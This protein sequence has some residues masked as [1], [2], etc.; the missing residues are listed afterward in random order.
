[1]LGLH[2]KWRSTFMEAWPDEVIALGLPQE[3]VILSEQDRMAIGSRTAAFRDIFE[4]DEIAQISKDLFAA[5]DEKLAVFPEGGHARLGGCSFKKPGFFQKGPAYTGQ[6]LAPYIL[7][8]N[9]RVASLLASSLED[10]FDVGLFIRPWRDMPR[11][12]EFRLFMR[13]R[14]FV[15]ASQYFHTDVY[16]QIEPNAQHIAAALIKFAGSFLEV[17][18]LDDAIVDVFV[19]NDPVAGWRAILLD[20]NPLIS[21]ADPC[22]FTWHNDGD[23]DRGLRFRRH[24][25]QVL[26]MAPLPFAHAS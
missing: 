5:A 1:M 18:H 21:R 8:E 12:S 3:Q 6:D 26:S 19:E 13:N 14:G 7:Q 17:S 22:L 10:R 25:R 23:F 4:L 20:I 15:G 2:E 16:P 9:P 11:W 24:D